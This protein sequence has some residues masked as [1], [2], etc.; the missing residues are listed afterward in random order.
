MASCLPVNDRM[1]E[2]RSEQKIEVRACRKQSEA[3]STEAL[4]QRL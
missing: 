3:R 1:N 4:L 2:W